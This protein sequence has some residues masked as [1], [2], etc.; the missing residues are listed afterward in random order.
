MLGRNWDYSFITHYQMILVMFTSFPHE[1]VHYGE[2]Q[3]TQKI[4]VECMSKL[5]FRG[6]ILS[7]SCSWRE[8]ERTEKTG[9]QF[10]DR[11]NW[12][13]RTLICQLQ[14]PCEAHVPLNS[15]EHQEPL[16]LR[17]V[18]GHLQSKWKLAWCCWCQESLKLGPL[19]W[20]HPW[21]NQI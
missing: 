9:W 18:L 13:V 6:W 21:R 5:L 17:A 15:S 20:G 16:L 19:F 2:A 12:G 7:L 3:T 1:N 14:A 4:S 8:S 10:Y 11:A